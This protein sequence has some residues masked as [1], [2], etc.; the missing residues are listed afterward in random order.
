AV[1][2][3]EIQ[4]PRAAWDEA[5]PNAIESHEDHRVLEAGDGFGVVPLPIGRCVK[6]PVLR[7]GLGEYPD[8]GFNPRLELLGGDLLGRHLEHLVASDGCVSELLGH[9]CLPSW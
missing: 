5:P 7:H 2:V 4:K 1:G 3:I 6:M 8:A 9:Q